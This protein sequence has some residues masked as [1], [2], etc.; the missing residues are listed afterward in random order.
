M[1]SNV[2]TKRLLILGVESWVLHVNDNY[3]VFKRI[4]QKSI[5]CQTDKSVLARQ[6]D[7]HEVHLPGFALVALEACLI[8]QRQ[9]KEQ[10]WW[11]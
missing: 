3:M 8:F 1:S 4:L 5:D 2:L 11:K 6:T 7:C 9:A 10:P